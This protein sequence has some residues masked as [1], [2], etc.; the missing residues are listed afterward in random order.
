MEPMSA[1][2][3]TSAYL[4][5]TQ[6]YQ[7]PLDLL[8]QLIERAELDITKLALAQVTDQ[9]LQHLEA[10]PERDP[11]EVS[12]F[13]VV[14]AKLLQIKSEFLLPR[15]SLADKQDEDAG[16]SLIQQLL[17][18]KVFKEIAGLLE[19][20]EAT[21]LH[22]YLRIAAIPSV[23]AQS[24]LSGVGQAD[25]LAA[26]QFVYANP[27]KPQQR[28]LLDTVA[29]S[30]PV[31]IRQKITRILEVLRN[32]QRATF[33]TFLEESRSRLEI[34]ITFLALLELV[35][36]HVLNVSQEKLFGNILVEPAEEWNGSDEFEIEF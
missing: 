14:A 9:F 11:N 27:P 4:V 20:R 22:T 30:S 18:Y 19:E 17:R 6:V 31:T 26:A 24:D 5:T 34:V 16:E 1:Y 3:Q 8:L 13:L 28:D 36:S 32:R 35:K 12:D 7:G 15:T 29:P 25:F 10:F 2:R 23:T 21:G 33:E